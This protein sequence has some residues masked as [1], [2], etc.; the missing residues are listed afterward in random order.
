MRL[1]SDASASGAGGGGG[2]APSGPSSAELVDAV[3]SVLRRA[4]VPISLETRKLLDANL[5]LQAELT[6]YKSECEERG[7]R[8]GKV[9]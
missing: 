6:Q 2:G 5:S 1:T 7:G 9:H 8:G 3:S 4:G